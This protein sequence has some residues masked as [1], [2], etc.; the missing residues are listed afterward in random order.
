[1]LEL[2]QAN[3]YKIYRYRSFF[4][5]WELMI[6]GPTDKMLNALIAKKEKETT[7]AISSEERKIIKAQRD[8]NFTIGLTLI[9]VSLIASNS[10]KEYGFKGHILYLMRSMKQ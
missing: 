6:M 8:L 4:S 2:K 1:M 7:S 10:H 3:T 5:D 9:T